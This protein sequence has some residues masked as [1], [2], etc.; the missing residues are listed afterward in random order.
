MNVLSRSP[1]FY[2]CFKSIEIIF[3]IIYVLSLT[4]LVFLTYLV[5]IQIC[6]NIIKRNIQCMFKIDSETFLLK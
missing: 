5:L 1:D 4:R 6:F 3:N 2:P